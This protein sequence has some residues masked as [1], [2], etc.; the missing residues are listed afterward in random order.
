MNQFI[1]NFF[2]GIGIG[3]ANVIPGVSGGTIALITGIFERVVNSLKS[4]NMTALKLLFTGKFKEFAKHTDLVFLCSVGLGVAVAILTI[5]RIF[6]FLFKNYPTY[7]WSFFF[8]MI[9]T[10]I[11]YVGKT[12]EKWDWKTIL[13]F[14]VGTAIAVFIAFGTPAKENDN[15]LY[16][17]ICGAVATCSMI[18]PGLS[19]SFV[20]VLMG[21]Y[22]LVMIQA[23]K[24]FDL[25]ILIPVVIGAAVGLIAFAHLLAWIYKN[26]R[27]ITI[28]LLTGFILGSMPIIW[29]WKHEVITYFGN[30]AK[31]TGYE[32]FKPE[33]DIHFATA[34]VIL[35]I[36]AAIIVLTEKMAANK[37]NK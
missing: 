15:F 5:A 6:D 31:T 25:G 17:M 8:G 20:L 10:S 36:G 23:V 22:Q 4:F 21:N 24:D 34:I 16:L 28:S 19:G 13:S 14:V 33:F 2:K 26:Y 30:E 35:L 9:L 1:N 32:Y 29:P 12:V 27:D 37:D 18:L 7:L 3:S 11:Y